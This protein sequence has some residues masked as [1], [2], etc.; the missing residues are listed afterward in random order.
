MHA[1]PAALQLGTI[2]AYTDRLLAAVL[3]IRT[4][5]T[6]VAKPRST[7]HHG[8][9]SALVMACAVGAASM[10]AVEPAPQQLPLTLVAVMSHEYTPS[11]ALAAL[12]VAY[13]EKQHSRCRDG[14]NSRRLPQQQE[15]EV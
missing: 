10:R 7:C 11:T 8:C 12:Y 4:K 14:A 2:L 5:P 6:Q 1:T 9:A 13:A 3:R 15:E